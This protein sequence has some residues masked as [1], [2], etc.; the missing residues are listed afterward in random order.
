MAQD[1][2]SKRVPS[3]IKGLDT[4]L[5]GGFLESGVYIFVG[6]P[7]AGKTIL[8]NQIAFRH[9][10]DGGRVVYVSLLAE[11]NARMF[12]H[13]E[14]FEFFDRSRISESMT[15]VSGY[16]ALEKDGL[17]GLLTMLRK[18]MQSRRATLLV[19]DGLVSAQAFA[20]TPLEVKKFVHELQTIVSLVEC[21]AFLLTS[22]SHAEIGAPERTMV[23]GLI[24]LS[25]E[26]LGV[27]QMRL[28]QVK[29]FR[30]SAHL[31]G[32]H[33]FSISPRGI[34]VFPRLEAVVT[35][36]QRAPSEHDG[37]ASTGVAELD[38]MFS[39]G[40]SRGCPTLVLGPPGSGKTIIALHFLEAGLRAGERC[41]YL[42]FQ[43]PP[44]R[45]LAK[46]ER[47]GISLQQYVDS[48]LLELKWHPSVD[49]LAD[50]LAHDVLDDVRGHAT[51]RVVIDS[52]DGFRDSIVV[53]DASQARR[54]TCATRRAPSSVPAWRCR[55]RT[56]P[57]S[58]T[59]SC[60]CGRWSSRASCCVSSPS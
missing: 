2:R 37:T 11:S 9:A 45:L 7:G 4:V 26:T 56:S 19:L 48:G 44:E 1:N 16:N 39:G 55:R 12:M 3:G 28:L 41:L 38:A 24:E 54:R 36:R 43:E 22:G 50:A 34:T 49:L 6:P 31:G 32:T 57:R 35:A 14:S 25:N 33:A 40:L 8:A 58:S 53:T 60:S 5:N 18:E 13:M 15:Y 10:A 51:R 29:K 20:A 59:T 52:L 21:T 27:R 42:G 47:V 17:P 46:A 30:G 23:D